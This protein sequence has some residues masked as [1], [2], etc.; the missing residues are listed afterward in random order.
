[1]ET[2]VINS[3]LK[4]DKIIYWVFTVI[5][6]LFDGVGALGF[7]TPLAVAG[8]RHMGFPDYFRVE[9]GIG[10]IIGGIIL[11]LPM[12]PAR[13]KEWAYVGF[14]IACIS[15]AVGHFVLDDASQGIFPLILLGFFIVSY[16]YY[17]KV[18]DSKA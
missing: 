10:K 14:G 9:L 17:H 16:V 5:V 2:A 11:I 18:T 12:I 4:R 13:L 3:T 1:M 7:N 8:I 6:V 15:A